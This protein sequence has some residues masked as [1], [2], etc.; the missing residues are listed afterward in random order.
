MSRH[1]ISRNVAFFITAGFVAALFLGGAAHAITETVF[2]YST[3]QKGYFT[4][5]AMGFSPD[6]S[7]DQYGTDWQ[8]GGLATQSQT[9][10]CAN[11]AVHV[12]NGAKLR[13]LDIWYK[14]SVRVIFMRHSLT[15]GTRHLI[16]SDTTLTDG[17][18]TRQH[19]IIAFAP[20]TVDNLHYA[21]SVGLCLQT[22]VFYAARVDYTYTNA[23]D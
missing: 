15:D 16:G 23:G 17:S 6:S 21:Y 7:G 12:P 4:I 10:G 11:T 19:G 14:T 9:F 22:G 2:N 5:E 8:S 1:L 13:A 18:A 3:T 20:E